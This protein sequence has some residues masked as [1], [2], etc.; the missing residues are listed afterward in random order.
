MAE[1]KQREYSRAE[2]AKHDS[3]A[4]LWVVRGNQVFDLTSFHTDHPGGSDV[5]MQ[6]GGQDI[7]EAMRDATI[8]THAIQA[9]RVLKD[10]YIGEITADERQDYADSGL[11]RDEMECVE[12]DKFLDLTRPLVMQMWNSKFTRD[13]YIREVHK[14][15]HLPQPAV[16]FENRFL[17]AF[18]RTPWWVIPLYWCP[19]LATLLVL[20]A[21]YEP[22]NVML[23]GFAFGLVSWTLMEYSI[24]RFIF[25]YDENI[26]EGMLAQMAH[27]LLHGVHHYLP[28]DPLRLVMPP[29]LSTFLGLNI[30][31][32]LCLVFTPGMVHAVAAGLTAGYVMYDECH[33]WLHHGTSA[34]KYL[35]QL[36]TY[37][38]RHHYKDFK[39]GFGITSD[40]W[41]NIFGTQFVSSD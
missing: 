10:F 41:D 35:C 23:V 1:A 29:A 4:S 22:F 7:T 14:A 34:N 27:F 3:A 21:R 36:K 32:L 30:L 8:H 16:F 20:G 39:A 15:H 11:G 13:F 24:H 25:H 33:Y 18:T 28:M 2:V 19:I 26:P 40:F 31:G 38:L 9:Y 6:F 17:E 37:H 12:E 5:L